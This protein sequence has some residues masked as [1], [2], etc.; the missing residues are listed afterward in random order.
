MINSYESEY[1]DKCENKK[2]SKEHDE[3]P[4]KISVV[5]V[6]QALYVDELFLF[7]VPWFVQLSVSSSFLPV[8]MDRVTVRPN[9]HMLA[10]T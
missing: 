2:Q 6:I 4:Y 5:V 7:G 8:A 3:W 1:D 10:V 9:P